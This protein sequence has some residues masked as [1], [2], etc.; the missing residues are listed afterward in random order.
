MSR[1]NDT[2]W[3]PRLHFTP[4]K[5]WMND[6][7][8]PMYWNGEYHLFYQYNPDSNGWGPMHWGHAVSSDMFGWQELPIPLRPDKNGMIYT[9]STVFDRYNHSGLF[10]ERGGLVALYT[11]HLEDPQKANPIECQ[12]LAYSRDAYHW[13]KL[14]GEAVL[15]N[16]GSR[17]FRDPKVFYHE[18]TERWIMVLS[19]GSEVRFYASLDL[20]RW[21]YLS[22][23]GAELESHDV[24]WECPDLFYLPVSNSHSDGRWILI[25]HV[26]KGLPSELSGA[27][28]FVGHFDGETFQAHQPPKWVDKGHDFYAAQS[29]ANLPVQYER[30]IWIAWASHWTYSH[31]T[32]TEQWRGVLTLPRQLGLVKAG[33][34]FVLA[35]SPVRELQD[36][37]KRS[38]LGQLIQNNSSATID[39]PI[40]RDEA[41]DLL[42][43]PWAGN[44]IRTELDFGNNRLLTMKLNGSTGRVTVDRG[45]CGL[46]QYSKSFHPCSSAR[47]EFK[48]NRTPGG[49]IRL[50]W[51][52]SIIEVFAHGGI[53][54]FTD[55]AFVPTPLRAIRVKTLGNT[56]PAQ[57]FLYELKKNGS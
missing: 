3:R 54:V 49:D 36:L 15:P 41:L 25:T 4:Q 10:D 33:E 19:V 28:Y 11:S 52:R 32:P 56:Q 51:D 26:G 6:P 29:W 16:D 18:S 47:P 13:S 55:L 9:G 48:N 39:F 5:G 53:L 50:I 45:K 23:F 44:S 30:T 35:Q 27:Q 14:N 8:G 22:T 21:Q 17:D 40:Q 34:Q 24:V 38:I 31:D 43:Q 42:I 12:R 57:V 1:N 20:Q 46:E 37:R 7:C 2:L